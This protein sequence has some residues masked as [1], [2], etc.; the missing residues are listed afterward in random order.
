MTLHESL[1]GRYIWDFSYTK[2]FITWYTDS[3]AVT[4]AI[5]A[6]SWLTEFNDLELIRG[7]K[8]TAVNESTELPTWYGVKI[9]T[10]RGIGSIELRHGGS[11]HVFR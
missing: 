2:Q 9:D 10:D 3:G 7:A 1:A 8:V 4:W 5:L 6:A 11:I